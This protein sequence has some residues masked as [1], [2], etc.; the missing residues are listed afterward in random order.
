[1]SRKALKSNDIDTGQEWMCWEL[2]KLP[3]L[4][5]LLQFPTVEDE[6]INLQAC[7]S[8]SAQVRR[9]GMSRSQSDLKFMTSG[10][11][12]GS[13]FQQSRFWGR[14]QCWDSR[15]WDFASVSVPIEK[16]TFLLSCL[17]SYPLVCSIN[18]EQNVLC[19]CKLAP[20]SQAR[21]KS[22]ACYK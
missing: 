7:V 17:L 11:S 6:I 20:C 2:L 16:K 5:N 21:V 8:R 9:E 14:T 10:I 13:W 15:Q 22:V 1:M 3:A 18:F 4:G 12:Q 19:A